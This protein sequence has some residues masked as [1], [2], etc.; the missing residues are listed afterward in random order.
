MLTKM[1]GATGV[2]LSAIGQGSWDLPERG[3]RLADAKAA[4]RRGV[5]L[6]LTHIDTAE[7]YG[8]G[9]VEE[10]IG[11]AIAGIPREQLFLTSKVL[12]SNASF[13]GVIAACERSLERIKVDYLDLY[14]LHWPS[15]LP[16]AETMRA[17]ESL[18]REGKTRY[19]GVSNFDLAGV[20]EAQ[21]Y[22]GSQKLACNQVLYHLCERGIEAEM[23]PYCSQQGIAVVGYT[24]F[25][26][27][28]FP[29]DGA[30]PGGVLARTGARYGKTSRQV[31]LNFLTRTPALFAIPKASCVE[32]VQENAGATGWVLDPADVAAIEAAYPV[33]YDG[34]LATL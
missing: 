26:R 23:L 27:G 14:L 20:R 3:S 19:I 7:M 16:L 13:A 10:I 8:N 5:E 24:P 34:T 9:S 11:Q 25:G 28:R 32:H 31:I 22:L 4:L 17:L 12:P 6:G 21:S 15:E 29:R 2:E 33:Q 18:V 30:A 1:F